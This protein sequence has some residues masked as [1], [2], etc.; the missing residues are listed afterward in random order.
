M[1]DAFLSGCGR[2]FSDGRFRRNW[3]FYKEVTIANA[4]RSQFDF[5]RYEKLSEECPRIGMRVIK[6]RVR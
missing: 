1:K 2:S 5:E 6:G 4:L 3:F